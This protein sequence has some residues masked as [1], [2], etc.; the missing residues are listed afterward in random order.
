LV[1]SRAR[2]KARYILHK[3][4]QL[5][6]AYD[7]KELIIMHPLRLSCLIATVLLIQGCASNYVAGFAGE[8]R[9][10]NHSIPFYM[11]QKAFDLEY[12]NCKVS[13]R[14]GRSIPA[15]TFSTDHVRT[16]QGNATI[17]ENGQRSTVYYEGTITEQPSFSKGFEV[18]YGLGSAIAA[19][20]A[21][22]KA[23]VEC[24]ES[25]G[26]VSVEKYYT[27]FYMNENITFNKAFMNLVRAGYSYPTKANNMT[28][29]L[30]KTLSKPP[31]GKTPAKLEYAVLR[32]HEDTSTPIR[33]ETFVKKDLSFLTQCD[34]GESSNG[35]RVPK[36]STIE[37]FYRKL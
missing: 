9:W 11:Q 33:C 35:P 24:I 31:I 23:E 32:D 21:L 7:Q 5:L 2:K 27:P 14:A 18:G 28:L 10:F 3:V 30:N 6:S 13:A 37:I 12:Q 26:W 34:N 4:F 29:L 19:I 36:G 17:I 25:L 8:R 20:E 16:F 22:N 15:V 1:L